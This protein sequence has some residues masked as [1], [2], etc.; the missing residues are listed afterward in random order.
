MKTITCWCEDILK[1]DPEKLIDM[2]ALDKEIRKESK[3]EFLKSYLRKQL[4]FDKE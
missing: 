1:D 3:E 2:N 4:G